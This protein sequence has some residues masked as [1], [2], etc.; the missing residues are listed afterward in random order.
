ME[1]DFRR[2]MMDKFAKEDKLEQL[3]QQ[4]RRMKEL[5]HKKEVERMWLER[6]S[7]YRA[8]KER[9]QEDFN[10]GLDNVRWEE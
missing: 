3:A 4:K 10:R 9:E 7:A 5:E 1:V 8:E 6:L 2:N